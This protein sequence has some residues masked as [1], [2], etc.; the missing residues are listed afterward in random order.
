MAMIRAILAIIMA[1]H[2]N[3]KWQTIMA[4]HGTSNGPY[5]AML[6]ARMAI[7]MAIIIAIHGNTNGHKWQ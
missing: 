7:I 6:M 3:A 5:M 2:G 4:I 1:I